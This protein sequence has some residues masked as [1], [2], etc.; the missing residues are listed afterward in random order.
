LVSTVDVV[1][2]AV[3]GNDIAKLSNDVLNAVTEAAKTSR[4][5][6]SPKLTFIYTSGTWVHG[7]NRQDIKTDTSPLTSPAPLVAWRV[8]QEQRVVRSEVLNGIVIRPAILYGRSGSVLAGLFAGAAQGKVQWYGTPGQ[9]LALIH[10]DDLADL[11][12]RAAEKAQLVGGKIF[13][14]AND[15]TESIDDVLQ[16][17]AAV[18]G[19]QGSPE[20]LDPT[21]NGEHSYRARVDGI[22]IRIPVAFLE[23]LSTTSL[24]RPYLGYALLGWQPRKPG[25]VD[26]LHV[27]YAAWKASA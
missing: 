27:Y 22:L 19:A 26:G 5:A 4:P 25:F 15:F 6:G 13:D 10:A 24:L 1:V 2:E 14:A 11:Y 21:G 23:A 17:L 7:E 18:T 9:R 8:K 16:K 12:V 3:G 20:F